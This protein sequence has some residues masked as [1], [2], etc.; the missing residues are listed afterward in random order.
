LLRLAPVAG[1]ERR[2]GVLAPGLLERFSSHSAVGS[3][4]AAP[5][6][7]IQASEERKLRGEA[8]AWR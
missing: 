3:G 8:E 5:P 1:F 6:W 2:A 4:G 7:Q